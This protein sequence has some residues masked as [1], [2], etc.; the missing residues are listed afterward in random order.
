MSILNLT[1]H[2]ATPDQAAA[3]VVNLSDNTELKKLLTFT[4]LPSKSDIESKAQ[5]IAQIAKDNGA[6]KAMIAGAGYLM[7]HLERELKAVG[8]TPLHAFSE[9]VSVETANADGTVSKQNIF[10]HV[11]FIEA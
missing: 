1:Q 4:A 9:R 10:K 7:P 2:A 8:V 5:A 6:T 3:G 11:G